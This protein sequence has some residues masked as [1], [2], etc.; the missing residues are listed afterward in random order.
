MVLDVEK[1]CLIVTKRRP[2]S[3]FIEEIY[4]IDSIKHSTEFTNPYCMMLIRQLLF[5]KRP[6]CRQRYDILN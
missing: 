2:F 3:K 5:I 1:K 6:V 4:P